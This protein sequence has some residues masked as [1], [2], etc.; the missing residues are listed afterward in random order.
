MITRDPQ[1]CQQSMTVD[2]KT[3]GSQGYNVSLYFVDWDKKDR[4]T[5]IEVL[6]LKEMLLPVY[7]VRDYEES[8]YV[9]YNFNQPVRL[10][11]NHVRGC[12]AALSGV[13]F[14]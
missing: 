3:I 4:R 7:M 5:P 13:F 14:D 8:K 11:I 2:T 1:V 6:D 9:T 12:N 10:R